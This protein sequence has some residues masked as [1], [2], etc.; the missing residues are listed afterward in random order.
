MIDPST[1]VVCLQLTIIEACHWCST[2]G[3][4][5]MR[6]YGN[7]VG[8]TSLPGSVPRTSDPINRFYQTLVARNTPQRHSLSFLE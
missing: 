7:E 4:L 2:G 8:S 6:T 1:G 3:G 5:T